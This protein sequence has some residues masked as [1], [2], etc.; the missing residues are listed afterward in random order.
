M[1]ALKGNNSKSSIHN[2]KISWFL[3][4]TEKSMDT[5]SENDLSSLSPRKKV[6]DNK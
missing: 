4:Y 6:R 1:R 5:Q 2:D 3:L